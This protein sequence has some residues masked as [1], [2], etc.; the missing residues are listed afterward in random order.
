MQWAASSSGDRWVEI[1]KD[2]AEVDGLPGY[3][4]P[5][6]GSNRSRIA[7][8]SAPI[9]VADG[10]Y[11]ECQVWHSATGSLDVEVDPKTWFAIVAL[12]FGAFRDALAHRR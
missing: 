10:D 3:L 11:F 2:G 5:T 9:A 4:G 8:A 6:D 12:E 1:L 7:L